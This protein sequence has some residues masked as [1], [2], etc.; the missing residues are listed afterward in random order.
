VAS[1]ILKPSF[2]RED[3]S[4]PQAVGI[5]IA[6]SG[7]PAKTKWLLV[8]SLAV[9]LIAGIGVVVLT[10]HRKPTVALA[11]PTPTAIPTPR[12]I[13]VVARTPISST[14]SQSFDVVT[15]SSK[16]E[17]GQAVWY[18]NQGHYELY[19]TVDGLYSDN[20]TVSLRRDDRTR[21]IISYDEFFK[22]GTYFVRKDAR[23]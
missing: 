13:T 15:A 21:R 16:I 6:P 1:A 8:V 18:S 10:G 14:P 7:C 12:P 5:A 9:A 17:V 19:G 20:K 2:S 22:T 3:A 23:Q 4:F 11:S